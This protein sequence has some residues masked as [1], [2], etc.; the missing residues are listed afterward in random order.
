[1]QKMVKWMVSYHLLTPAR[2]AFH[3]LFEMENYQIVSLFKKYA[4]IFT[5][6][7]EEDVG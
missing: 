4:F 1:M 6:F 7:L 5:H 3:N 2:E